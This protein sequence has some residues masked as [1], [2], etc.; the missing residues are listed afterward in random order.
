MKK[1]LLSILLLLITCSISCKKEPGQ[2]TERNEVIGKGFDFSTTKKVDL[3]IRLLTNNN[4]PLSGVLVNINLT[5]DRNGEATLFKAISDSQGMIKG[6]INIPTYLDTLAIDAKYIG[7]PRNM[8]ALIKNKAINCIIGGED[9][10]SGDI[11]EDR[12]ISGNPNA[13]SFKKAAN[14]PTVR[15]NTKTTYEYMGS[16]DL[17]GRPLYREAKG[18][19]ISSELLA[20]INSSLPEEKDVREHHPNYLSSSSVSTLN[21][22]KTS[23]VFVSFVSEGAAYYN[24][25]GYYTYPTH[26]PPQ[27]IDE[28]ETVY[29]LFPNA[30]LVGQGGGLRS[31]DKVKLGTFQAGTSVGFVLLSNAWYGQGVS[32]KGVKYFSNTNL[33]PETS[34]SLKRHTV[35]LNYKDENKFVI[36]FEDM[37]RDNYQNDHDFNDVVLLA[38]SNPID[39]ISTSGISDLDQVKDSDKDGIPDKLDFFPNDPSRAYVSYYPAQNTWGTI[40]FEDNW[41]SKGDYDLNDMVVNYRYTFVFNAK[42]QAVEMAGDYTV[43]AAGASF[44]NGFGVQF[45]FSPGIVSNATG[46]KFKDSFIQLMGNGLEAGQS[47]AVII[48]FDNTN[49]LISNYAGAYFV[50]TKTS[51]PKVRGDTAHVNIKFVTPIG[52]EILSNAPFNAFLISNKRR[53]YEIHLPGY[54]ATDKADK[55]LFGTADDSS[56]LAGRRY[57][58]ARD[59]APWAISFTE[60][61]DYPTEESSITNAYL[62]FDDWVSSQGTLFAD[63]YKNTDYGFRNRELIYSK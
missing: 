34:S 4:S 44:E 62:H 21:I 33:N 29:Y 11:I 58:L 2:S 30:S 48:P 53:G 26:A 59:N 60:K 20:F 6:S 55:S 8:K 36:G 31:G 18:D 23:E 14:L 57:Y 39:G 22:T 63:W 16:F 49:A 35:V 15:K 40:A 9:G 24:A 52:P 61:F 7:L 43:V 27:E 56:N 37:P 42:N 10:V 50:N 54:E 46:Q 25:I 12:G 1:V 51:M 17:L 47:K 13:V 45:P 32:N 38:Y 5:G 28:I 3:N 41:P 19:V